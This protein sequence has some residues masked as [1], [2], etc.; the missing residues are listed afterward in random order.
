[1]QRRNNIRLFEEYCQQYVILTFGR[2]QFP[3]LARPLATY[4]PKLGNISPRNTPMNLRLR[5]HPDRLFLRR[6]ARQ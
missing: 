3:T 5:R 1:M 6:P 4:L 2:G